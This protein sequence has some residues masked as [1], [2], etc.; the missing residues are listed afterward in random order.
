MIYGYGAICDGLVRLFRM[1]FDKQVKVVAT[2]GDARLIS[3]YASSID[4]T[5]PDL[6][7]KG[8]YLLSCKAPQS[9]KR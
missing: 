4:M 2:G 6:C 3:E 1:R 8:L 9:K 5:D 7:M